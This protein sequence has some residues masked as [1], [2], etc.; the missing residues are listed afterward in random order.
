MKADIPTCRIELSI[1]FFIQK[2]KYQLFL[3]N[4]LTSK[5]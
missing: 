3:G 2:Q 4:E 1:T 5:R